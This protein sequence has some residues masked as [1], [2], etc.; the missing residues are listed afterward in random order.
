MADKAAK[1]KTDEKQHTDNETQNVSSSSRLQSDRSSKSTA[2]S[3]F[4]V[5]SSRST[6]SKADSTKD[7][8]V[9]SHVNSPSVHAATNALSVTARWGLNWRSSNAQLLTCTNSSTL[10]SN[11]ITESDNCQQ[12]GNL[13]VDEEVADKLTM[14]NT[15]NNCGKKYRNN[16]RAVKLYESLD[17]N[18][19]R[20]VLVCQK[21][22]S[23]NHESGSVMR[24]LAAAASE[25]DLSHTLPD[26]PPLN[27][28][29][30]VGSRMST[31]K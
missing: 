2:R 7:C 14:I 11:Q 27:L 4:R 18:V 31:L 20:H 3:L 28:Q 30:G 5:F 24:P 13:V 16:D 12:S 9:D 29:S 1:S 25:Q 8:A 10:A 21:D 6:E 26:V 15:F 19:Q 22:A 17:S 23:N